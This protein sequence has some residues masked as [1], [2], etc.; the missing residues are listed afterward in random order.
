VPT[1]PV[2]GDGVSYRGIVWFVVILVATTA[3]CQL[4]V[5]GMYEISASRLAGSEAARAPLAAPAP[6]HGQL[7]PLPPGPNLLTSEPT[8]LRTFRA[9]EDM[10]LSTYGW[11][12]QN[13]GTVRIPIDRAKELILERKLLPVAPAETQR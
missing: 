5:W 4:L 7:P 6:A 12:D 2:E 13:A 11:V 8:N 3:F 10:S 9:S 1:G